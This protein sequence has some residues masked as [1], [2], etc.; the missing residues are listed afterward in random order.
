[1]LNGAKR[2]EASPEGYRNL[3]KSRSCQHSGILQDCFHRAGALESLQRFALQAFQRSGKCR[4]E[5]ADRFV[6]QTFQRSG[7]NSIVNVIIFCDIDRGRLFSEAVKG[8][9]GI[10]KNSESALIRAGKIVKNR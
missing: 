2:S 6:L 9:K 4:Q 1:M 8:V 5:L 3:G 7:E 10:L